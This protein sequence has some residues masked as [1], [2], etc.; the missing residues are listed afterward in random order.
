MKNI[1]LILILTLTLNSCEDYLDVVPEG[2]ATIE[3]IYRTQLQAQNFLYT[4]YA[5]M[6]DRVSIQSMPDF[7]AG[8][9]FISGYYG[10]VRWFSYKSLLYGLESASNTYF[11]MWSTT[12]SSYPTGARRYDIYGTIRHCYNFLN[13]IDRVPDITEENLTR[14]KGEALFLIAYYHQTLLEYYGPI[15]LVDKEIPLNA[16]QDEIYPQ[17]ATYDECVEFI[18]QKYDEA[19]TFLPVRWGNDEVGRATKA[20]ALGQ[21][22][23]LLL[24]AASPLVNGNSEFYADF[25]NPDGEHLIPQ[26]YDKEKWKK[27]MQA[28]KAA[29]DFCESNGYKLYESPGAQANKDMERGKQNYHATFVGEGTGS[30]WN[31]DEFLFSDTDIG[32]LHYTNKNIAP[33]IEFTSYTGKGFRGYVF[34]TWD[35]VEMYYTKNGLPLDVDPLTKDEDLYSVA[36]GDSTA[37]LHRNREPRFYASVGF[38][39]GTYQ[40]NGGEIILKCRR[41]EM[42]QNDG[43]P[44][45]EYQ[46]DNGYYSQK[47]ISSIDSYNKTSNRISYNDYSYP[48][49]RMAELYL[50]YAE[51]DFEYNGSLSAQ[52]LEYLNKVRHRA[53]LPNFEDSWAMVGGIPSG[54]ALRKV[55]RQERTIEFLME[56]RRFHD[57]RRWKIAEEEMMRSQKA[58]NLA[59]E[60]AEE[61]YQ[62]T[63]MKEGGE[64]VFE[65][66]KTYWLAVPL[67]QLNTNHNLVQNPG[68]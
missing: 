11:G 25:K 33:R 18:A 8:G 62:I 43:N 26:S 7:G 13:N 4:L 16:S 46:S 20:T 28:S 45:N 51:A 54:A 9:D 55:L 50:S 47:W 36:P 29:I 61:F 39:R 59:G 38:D 3:D 34:P 24:Y 68:Y 21:K 49:L 41:G 57:I 10:S 22:A 30:F 65:T 27:A 14:W 48:L 12:S 6:P 42:Q 58:W 32:A 1:F 31:T 17:R 56:G 67:D 60:T 23:R 52:S 53:G 15:V 5:T 63:T 40:I 2:K 44:K 35:C 37:R 19:A 66:P 64:R